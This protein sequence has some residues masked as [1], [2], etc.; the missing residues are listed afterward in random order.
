MSQIERGE[1]VNLDQWDK[2]ADDARQAFHEKFGFDD[3]DPIDKFE[4][5]LMKACGIDTS[6]TKI[7]VGEDGKRQEV[8]WTK[9]DVIS[10]MERSRIYSENSVRKQLVEEVAYAM[11]SQ[12]LGLRSAKTEAGIE[13][14]EDSSNIIHLVA[15]I[16]ERFRAA[17][18]DLTHDR[19]AVRKPQHW[20]EAQMLEIIRRTVLDPRYVVVSTEYGGFSFRSYRE[21]GFIEKLFSRE[22]KKG[23]NHEQFFKG[24]RDEAYTNVEKY[25]EDDWVRIVQEEKVYLLEF[26]KRAAK[27]AQY[28]TDWVRM[29]SGFM[30]GGK[31]IHPDYMLEEMMKEAGLA[32]Q[33]S[34]VIQE[35]E[36]LSKIIPIIEQRL[37]RRIDFR[38]LL[39]FFNPMES[40][41][42][43]T[44]EVDDENR[45]IED[46]LL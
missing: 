30:R 35:V 36:D 15:A 7:V 43:R 13:A 2:E 17:P 1:T 31:Y 26:I 14:S 12:F 23:E 27:S 39:D 42:P 21:E 20:E 8:A 28:R 10:A 5:Q 16:L 41:K 11:D 44:L 34:A 22:P 3:N 33:A 29:E 46:Y 19:G 45:Y 40:L 9:A 18:G 24:L 4:G 6:R 38:Q 37:G 25:S 32:E